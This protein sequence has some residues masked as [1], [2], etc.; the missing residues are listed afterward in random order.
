MSLASHIAHHLHAWL[1]FA[2]DHIISETRCHC[3]SRADSHACG[4]GL[5]GMSYKTEQS[6][7]LFFPSVNPLDIIFISI[8]VQWASSS[9]VS[10]LC[11]LEV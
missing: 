6:P 5:L 11:V 7:T 2:L 3:F 8:R 9:P 1:H 10:P 4:N